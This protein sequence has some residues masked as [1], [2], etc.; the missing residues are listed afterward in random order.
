MMIWRCIGSG[1]EPTWLLRL[2]Q[3]FLRALAGDQEE[4]AADDAMA[5]GLLKRYA[6]PLLVELADRG[7]DEAELMLDGDREGEVALRPLE[8]KSLCR[9]PRVLPCLR[10]LPVGVGGFP[11][12]GPVKGGESSSHTR[13]VLELGVTGESSFGAAGA[14]CLHWGSSSGKEPY[15]DGDTR[16]LLLP[17]PPPFPEGEEPS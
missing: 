7:G 15:E 10:S 11:A 8:A 14:T 13:G 4:E 16:L 9:E 1:G 2:L 17:P 12:V 6:T 5:A 3:W